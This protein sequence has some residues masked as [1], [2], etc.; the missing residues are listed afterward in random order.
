MYAA[1]ALSASPVVRGIFPDA[2]GV[3]PA[4]A[5]IV[6]TSINSAAAFDRIDVILLFRHESSSRRFSL[7]DA[8]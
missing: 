6:E 2:G 8:L 5:A 1:V 7:G 3:L 4:H